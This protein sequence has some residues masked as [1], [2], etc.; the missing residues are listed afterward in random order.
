DLSA[1]RQE[2]SKVTA[3][4]I[5]LKLQVNAKKPGK[6][7]KVPDHLIEEIVEKDAE[8][9]KLHASIS[10]TETNLAQIRNKVIKEDD[11]A[12]RRLED[13][14]NNQKSS[15]EGVLKAARQQASAAAQKRL[16]QTT[17]HEADLAKEKIEYLEQYKEILVASANQLEEESKKFNQGN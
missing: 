1:T 10:K 5:Q 2:L 11:P 14:L 15:L 17:Q 7:S 6:L 16:E 8:V 4:I 3:Q 9:A 13:L 12:V